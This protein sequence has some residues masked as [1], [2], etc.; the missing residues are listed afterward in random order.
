MKPVELKEKPERCPKCGSRIVPIIYG[1]PT[2]EMGEKAE[3]K[4]VIL[5]GCIV[6][7]DDEGNP[8]V[9]RWGCVKCG[10]EFLIKDEH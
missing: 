8:I 7:T 9:P 3:R 10:R 5:G 1:E 2:F 6:L 4:E